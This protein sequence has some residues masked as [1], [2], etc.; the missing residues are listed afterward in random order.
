MVVSSIP[1][2]PENVPIDRIAPTTRP[3]SRVRGAQRWRSLL[4]AHWSVPVDALRSIVPDALELD[5]LDGVA[6]VGVVPFAM[7]GVRPS[8][9]PERLAFQ[10]LETNV[11][12]YVVHRGVPGVYFFSLEAAS[13]LAV[14]AART[15]WGLPYHHARMSI[16]RH[17][18]EI[19]YETRRRSSGARFAARYHVGEPLGASRPGTLEHFLLERYVLFVER[20]GHVFSGRVHHAPYPVHRAEIVEIEDE[21]IAAAGLPEVAGAPAFVHYSHGVDVAIF[22]LEQVP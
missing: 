13:R 4:F 15:F 7:E 5:L 21:L 19:R 3:D 8:W 6:Y 18:T 10:F 11:R 22:G 17:G 12:A 1:T 14:I 16:V 20:R 9:W 2:E